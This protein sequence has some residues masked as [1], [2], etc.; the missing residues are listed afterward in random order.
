M[1]S[2]KKLI[3]HLREKKFTNKIQCFIWR[4]IT[5]GWLN[6]IF[7]V[8]IYRTFFNIFGSRLHERIL[9]TVCAFAALSIWV[10]MPIGVLISFQYLHL[11]PFSLLYIYI[12]AMLW[13][14]LFIVTLISNIILIP[15]LNQRV[16]GMEILRIF[17]T[18]RWAVRLS[19]SLLLTKSY[20]PQVHYPKC[21][22]WEIHTRFKS[23][24]PSNKLAFTRAVLRDIKKL[25]NQL[26]GQCCFFGHTPLEIKRFLV[27][28]KTLLNINLQGP[29][30]S[31]TPVNRTLLVNYKPAPWHVYLI[32]KN[33]K[34]PKS[35]GQS[36]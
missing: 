9:S 20:R 21:T 2:S 10:Y 35:G 11:L 12:F 32:Q 14:M 24:K 30:L 15:W 1:D 17:P 33:E 13:L 34:P 3:K 31:K 36:R 18:S 29:F 19:I 8:T 4:C 27:L 7:P 28:S 22:F 6:F 26:D 16:L 5:S 23:G 25:T